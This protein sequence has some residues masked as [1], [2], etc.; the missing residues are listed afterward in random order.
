M[1]ETRIYWPDFDIFPLFQVHWIL[2][3]SPGLCFGVLGTE[4]TTGGFRARQRGWSRGCRLSCFDGS[5]EPLDP[6]KNFGILLLRNQILG[7]CVSESIE[8]IECPNGLATTESACGGE[9]M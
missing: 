6:R 4:N 3:I 7:K 5:I 9:Q 1:S 2:L 8:P